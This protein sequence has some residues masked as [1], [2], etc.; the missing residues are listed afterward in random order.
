VQAQQPN[1]PVAAPQAQRPANTN[2][3]QGNHGANGAPH[4]QRPGNPNA[5]HENR[6]AAAPQQQNL[7]Q[8]DRHEA[9]R[10]GGQPASRDQRHDWQGRPGGQQNYDHGRTDF[11]HGR[12]DYQHGRSDYQH[13]RGP[14][15][16][17][18]GNDQHWNR[19]WHQDRRYNWSNY[20][21][22]NRGVYRLSPYY[23]PYHGWGYRQLSVGFMLQPLFFG[24]TYWI[25]D[26]YTYRLPPVYGPYRWVRYYND[27]LLVNIYTGEVVDT[28]Y[29]IFW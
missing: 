9:W 20:R 12:A 7:H 25:A 3:W 15:G 22:S 27:A 8:P 17:Y 29:G 28:A 14:A 26:P 18:S 21:Y 1:R 11:D 6:P 10:E 13:D 24:S 16:H 2:P 4:E 5:W 19:D 23:A